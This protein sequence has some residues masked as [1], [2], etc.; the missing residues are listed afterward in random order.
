[1]A[2][3]TDNDVLRYGDTTHTG[4]SS[5]NLDVKVFTL[6]VDYADLGGA[7]TSI[8]LTGFPT[9]AYTFGDAYF[10]P[11]VAF[12]GE[13]DIAFQVGDTADQDGYCAS[14][15]LDGV[16]AGTISKTAGALFGLT[17]EADWAGDGAEVTFTATD[18]ADLTA[19]HGF[20]HV[21]YVQIRQCAE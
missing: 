21:P 12:A 11:T 1:M 20:V 4:A 5:D 9:N 16:A 17:Y 2:D 15:D 13:A 10:V 8:A 6:E 7:S 14:T 3:R 19:G 18:A